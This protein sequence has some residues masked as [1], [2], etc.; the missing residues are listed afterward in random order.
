MPGRKDKKTAV[1]RAEADSRAGNHPGNMF[2]HALNH[3]Q[4]KRPGTPRGGTTRD[5]HIIPSPTAARMTAQ[6]A[7]DQTS[8]DAPPGRMTAADADSPGQGKRL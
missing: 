2:I 3:R 4:R 5:S 6:A 1:N 8:G 7:H